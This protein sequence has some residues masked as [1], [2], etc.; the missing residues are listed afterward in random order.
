MPSV[1]HLN[2]ENVV[3][4]PV[5]GCSHTGLS[6]GMHLHVRQ[7]SG[8][9]HG[10]NGDV[11]EHLSFD[12]L[13]VVG[14]QEVEM[15]YPSERDVED[16][17]RLCPFCRRPFSGYQG[18]MI[19]LGQMEGKENHPE[20]S[21][22]QVEKDDC[23]VAHVDENRNVIEIVEEGSLMPSTKRRRTGVVD[24]SDVVDF[25]EW[26]ENHGYDD[27]VEKGEQMLLKQ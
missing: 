14:T 6:R 5:E 12:N 20:D 3:K 18:V 15:N 16:V 26:L 17:A 13:E 24:R 19:H 25:I 21:S 4:C 2:E 7:S 23:P 11:P 22:E 1:K 9:G 10:P 27:A 8:N